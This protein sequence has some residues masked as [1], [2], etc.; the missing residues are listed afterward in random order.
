MVTVPDE[1]P[2]VLGANSTLNEA[3][4]PAATV[5]GVVSPLTLKLPPLAEICE[6]VREAVPVFVSVKDWD[7]VCPWTMRPKL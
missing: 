5:A 3:V 7:L 2:A 1:L 4:P 6:I